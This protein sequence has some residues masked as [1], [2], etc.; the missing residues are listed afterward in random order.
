MTVVSLR[1]DAQEDQ[2]IKEYAKANNITV[3]ALFRN[4]VLEKIEDEIDLS[5]YKQAMSEHK[6]NSQ[7]I[8]FEE[9]LKEL[10]D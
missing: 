7:S 8:S 4:T 1:I 6:E 2:L 5:L 3:S 10:A 9:M